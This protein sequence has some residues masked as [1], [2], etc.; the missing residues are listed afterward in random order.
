V[1]GVEGGYAQSN[2]SDHPL[3]CQLRCFT[4]YK[5]YGLFNDIATKSK[6]AA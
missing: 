6:S 1:G 5:A 2:I 4:L 3:S